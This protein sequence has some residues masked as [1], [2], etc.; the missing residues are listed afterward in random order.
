MLGYESKD[1]RS[2]LTI[3]LP[4]LDKLTPNKCGRV[5]RGR[6]ALQDYLLKLPV[7]FERRPLQITEYGIRPASGD[8]LYHRD[9]VTVRVT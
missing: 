4:R 3:A 7:L 5:S 6:K 9:P 8:T 1:Q 2:S